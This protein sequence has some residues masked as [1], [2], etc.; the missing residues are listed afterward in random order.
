MTDIDNKDN[1]LQPQDESAA[2][3]SPDAQT[4]SS[5]EAKRP[6]LWRKILKITAWTIMGIVLFFVGLLAA[7]LTILRPETLTPIVV[8]IAN[9]NLNADV[10]INRVE[11]SLAGTF[12]MLN[13][14]V[15]GIELLSRDTRKLSA[16]YREEMGVPD[17]TDTVL[18]VK[19]ISG[20]LRLSSLLSDKIDLNDVVIDSP[21][22]NLVVVNDSVSNFNIFIEDED[23]T[24]INIAELPELA[25][26]HFEI[27]NPGPVRYYDCET[28]T[29]FE[30]SFKAVDLVGAKAPLYAIRFE[31]NVDAPLLME[32]F[33]FDDL[34]FALVGDLRWSQKK[35]YNIGLQNFDF[36]LSYLAGTVSTDI[37]FTNQLIINS[38]D[39][40][41]QPISIY[42]TLHLLPDEMAEAIAE[43]HQIPLS[44]FTE[45]ETDATVS[46]SA[47]LLKPF[48]AAVDGLPCLQADITVP[49]SYL[50]WENLDLN[51][52][53]A[54][55]TLLI[56]DQNLDNAVLTIN[57]FDLS[58]PATSLQ[59]K[60]KVT[61]LLTDPTFEADI[62]TQTSLDRLPP[63]LKRLF[64]GSVSGTLTANARI[65]GSVSMFSPQKFQ[66][67]LV[68]GDIG[69]KNFYW[70]ANDTVNMVYVDRALFN[71]GTQNRVKHSVTP[72]ERM[73]SGKVTVDSA[74]ILIGNYIMNVKDFACGLGARNSKH[75][76]GTVHP[77]G[78][79][80]RIGRFNF[81]SISDSAVV[82]VRDAGGVAIIR[83]IGDDLRRPEFIFKLGLGRLSAG[84]NSTRMMVSNATLDFAARR[85]PFTE[86]QKLIMKSADSIRRVSPNLPPDSVIA[87]AERIH[88]R[89]SHKKYPRVHPEMTDQSTE[90]ID[91]GTSKG[92]RRLLNRWTLE[93]TLVSDRARLF[94][95]YFPLRNRLRNINVAF[96][97]DTIRLKDVQY[98]AGHSD[99]TFSGE[100]TNLRRAL[101]SRRQ[102]QP[103]KIRFSSISDTIDINQLANSA[104][105]GSAYASSQIGKLSLSSLD[106]ENKLDSLI[107]A[108]VAD[109]P[110]AMAPLLIP[111]NVDIELNCKA[112]NVLYSDLILHKFSGTLMAYDGALNLHRLNAR[113]EVGD[114]NLSALY[115]GKDVDSLSFG[116]GMKLDRFNLHKFLDLVPAVDSMMPVLRDFSGIISADIACTTPINRN[117][118]FE[119]GRLNA[120]IQLAGSELVLLDPE[121]FKMLSKWLFFKDK[122]RNIIDHM[123]VQMAVDKGLLNIYP[124]IFNI[125][126]YKLGVQGHNDFNMNFDYHIAVL[127]SPVPFKFGI[128]IKGNP[129]KYKIRLGG[130]KFNEKTPLQVAFVDTT[131]VNLIRQIENVFRRGIRGAGMTAVQLDSSPVAADINLDANALTAQ[132][133]LQLYRQG[134][135]PEPPASLSDGENTPDSKQAKKNKNSKKNNKKQKNNNK[136]N[137]EASDPKA[138]SLATESR[139]SNPR[140]K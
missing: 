110:D 4:A 33:H 64:Q 136:N 22:A 26:N 105:A 54:S 116:F 70:L 102:R 2:T 27:K 67:L 25:I 112:D 38:L 28:T 15:N 95:P 23:T 17:Y 35:P 124:F 21:R 65:E 100:I 88:R 10:S 14:D 44:I 13:V 49:E 137:S 97:N 74:S 132:D 108:H 89:P 63:I 9:N 86:R 32:Y 115:M 107:G 128:N 50:R 41:L 114:I 83:P 34:R 101:T 11:L 82:R 72:G 92:L 8:S 113:S 140:Q 139:R 3:K 69:L 133:S 118:D 55:L 73:L 80:L 125:D 57:Y 127:K 121:T 75:I 20:G 123:E 91:F 126:R 29:R 87:M 111:R 117:M 58:G 109:A 43:E 19:S 68:E 45:L 135:I 31:G 119:L 16:D 90:V 138:L 85:K 134:M 24:A 96:N 93:G 129:D 103:L 47:R 94:T 98:K 130:A 12:P 61:H 30:A 106:D 56:P 46:I 60:G 53:K 59:Y 66:Q 71:F 36:R 52:L 51:K 37:D 79:G 99:I 6:P 78:G 76:R 7:T 122:K 84:D 131:R 5:M 39:V 104:F 1:I 81:L 18:T 48:N 120:A 42:K 77:M 40:K 62:S